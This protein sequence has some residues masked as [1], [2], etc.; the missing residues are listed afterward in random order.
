[1]LRCRNCADIALF[2]RA[3]SRTTGAESDIFFD[4]RKPSRIATPSVMD[5]QR[6]SPAR[7]MDLPISPATTPSRQ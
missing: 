4:T 5:N 2:N 6:C 1:M 3:T 7:K